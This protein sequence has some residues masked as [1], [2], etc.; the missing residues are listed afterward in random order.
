MWGSD[1]EE[2]CRNPLL[3]V[4]CCYKPKT[5]LPPKKFINET[6]IKGTDKHKAKSESPAMPN[7]M[8][9]LLRLMKS[10]VHK[11]NKVNKVLCTLLELL[12]ICK[13]K[14]RH[15]RSTVS[16]L[17]FFFVITEPTLGVHPTYQ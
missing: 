14:P 10:Y 5:A 17:P 16:F 8:V 4:Q 9:L 3:S 1:G 11:V 13:I 12:Y 15:D 6:K 2:V 7:L